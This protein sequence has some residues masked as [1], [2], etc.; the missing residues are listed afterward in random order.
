M[1]RFVLIE[2]EMLHIEITDTEDF[3][4][5][6]PEVFYALIECSA[7]VNKRYIESKD[8]PRISLVFL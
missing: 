8:K 1:T 7:F 6:L 5:R 4:S 2:N 3:N